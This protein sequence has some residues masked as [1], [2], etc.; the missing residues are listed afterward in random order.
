MAFGCYINHFYNRQRMNALRN[1]ISITGTNINNHSLKPIVLRLLGGE[2]HVVR[3]RT[4][5]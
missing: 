2:D 1:Q 5:S 4:V 3:R